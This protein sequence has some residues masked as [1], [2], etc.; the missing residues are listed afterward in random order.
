MKVDTELNAYLHMIKDISK[1]NEIDINK[2]N[3]KVKN[4]LTKNYYK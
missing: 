1:Q 4:N 3:I 2:D